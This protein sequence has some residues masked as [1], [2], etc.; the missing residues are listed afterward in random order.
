MVSRDAEEWGEPTFGAGKDDVDH[1][2]LGRIA[3]LLRSWIYR[4]VQCNRENRS[5]VTLPQ[6]DC[7]ALPYAQLLLL[8]TIYNHAFVLLYSHSGAS[9]ITHVLIANRSQ[10]AGM[11]ITGS[12][13]SLWSKW[14]DMQCVEDCNTD[15]PVLYEQPVWQTLQMFRESVPHVVLISTPCSHLPS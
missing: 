12:S 3:P 4:R 5:P 11:I 2:A 14:Q 7:V 13:N 10:L 15:H 6:T 8:S 9:D 1:K